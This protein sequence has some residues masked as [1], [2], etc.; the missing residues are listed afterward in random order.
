MWRYV[1]FIRI[2]FS[3]FSRFLEQET[4]ATGLFDRVEVGNPNGA[5]FS[6]H[7]LRVLT[8]LDLVIN[9][10]DTAAED[11]ELDHLN[12]Q[13]VAMGNIKAEYFTVRDQHS[14]KAHNRFRLK[15]IPGILEFVANLRFVCSL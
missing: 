11:A 9:L 3:P 13:H 1:F 15:W 4:E 14:H 8:G 6:G 10:L 12:H 7:M 5:K 2:I